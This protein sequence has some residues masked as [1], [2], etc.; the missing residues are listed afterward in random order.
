[1]QK[2]SVDL[3]DFFWSASPWVGVEV[4]VAQYLPTSY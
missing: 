3:G 1:M 4:K 2:G